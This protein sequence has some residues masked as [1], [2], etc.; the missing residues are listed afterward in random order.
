M[1]VKFSIHMNPKRRNPEAM[2]S[3]P[4]K[5]LIYESPYKLYVG[6]LVWSVQ[7]ED[8]RNHFCRFGNVTSAR[9]L[10]DRKGGKNRAYGFLSFSSAAELEAAKSLNGE[11][12]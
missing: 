12:M 11:V 4:I 6:N 9:V 7:P 5:N 1:R 2:N 8:L 10:H 3:I